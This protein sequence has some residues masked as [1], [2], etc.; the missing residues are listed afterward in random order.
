MSLITTC[1]ACGTAFHVEPAQLA[2][3]RGDVGCGKCGHVFNALDRLAEIL[4]E[5]PVAAAMHDQA[6]RA[7]ETA[8]AAE[9]TPP[10]M[11]PAEPLGLELIPEST[12]ETETE[13]EPSRMAAPAPE[14]KDARP[15][16]PKK[17]VARWLLPTLA[18]PL[19]LLALGQSL[20]FWRT[21]LAIRLPQLR[22]YLVQACAALDCRVELPRKAALLSIDDSDLQKDAKRDNVYILAAT[23]SNRANYAQAY[24]LLEL[25]LTELDEQPVLR[26]T[27]EPPEYLRG[28]FDLEQGFAAG[29][30]I[31]V[32]LAFTLD[33]LKATGYRVYVT[34]P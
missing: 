11:P 9:T 27:F 31:H 16:R 4:P 34:Y 13:T 26:R 20:H 12:P 10:T 2:A 24:P 17:S 15:P 1:P 6:A 18:L 5:P 19:L 22:P 21:E 33:Q 29:S 14:F 30:E 23:I 32:K 3:H 25:T 8:A 28:R 7:T